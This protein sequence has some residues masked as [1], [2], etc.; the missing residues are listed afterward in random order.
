MNQWMSEPFEYPDQP[1]DRGKVLWEDDL[2]GL[3]ERWGRYLDVDGDGIP[4]RTIPGN[5]H[6]NGAYFARGTGHSEYAVYSE[7]PDVWQRVNARLKKKYDGSVKYLPKPKPVLHEMEGAE[8]GI[9]AVGSPDGAIQEAR[10]RLADGQIR[11]NYLRI[12]SIPF[13][14]SVR[15]FINAHR[16][17]FVIEL[18]REG[19]LHQLLTLQAPEGA[20]RLISIHFSD[21]LPLTARWIVES[22]SARLSKGVE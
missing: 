22:V 21:G 15:K 11:T 14:P 8:I 12:R 5:Q 4:Y 19:Q 13:D 10:Q 9:L 2:A 18:N 17:I 20:T 6:P 1:M 3:G 7:D 16:V